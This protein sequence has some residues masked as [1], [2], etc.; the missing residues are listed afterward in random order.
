MRPVRFSKRDSMCFS[1]TGDDANADLTAFEMI[2]QVVSPYQFNP[3]YINAL[4]DLR[5]REIDFAEV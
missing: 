3:L 4:E 5:N 2:P 1:R